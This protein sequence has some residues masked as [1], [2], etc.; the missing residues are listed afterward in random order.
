VALVDGTAG[1]VSA[2]YEYGPFGETVRATGTIATTNP[3]RSQ[4]SSRMTSRTLFTTVPLLQSEHGAMASQR[5]DGEKGGNN[6]Y[7]SQLIAQSISSDELGLC[8]ALHSNWFKRALGGFAANDI[9]Y[10]ARVVYAE[11]SCSSE[12]DQC[13]GILGDPQSGWR[14]GG[15]LEDSRQ[16]LLT[17]VVMH[18]NSIKLNL[19]NQTSDVLV[20]AS[21]SIAW[22]IGSRCLVCHSLELIWCINNSC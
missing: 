2:N 1:T 16:H 18:Q 19:A 12:D 4:Q 22:K 17:G 6:P 13:G 20:D 11:A 15:F 21:S 7:R 3:L 10:A 8:G 5:S 14:E 9:N